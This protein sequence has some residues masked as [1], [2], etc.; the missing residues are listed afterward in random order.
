MWA[1]GSKQ[2][3]KVPA[4]L[5]NKATRRR[6]SAG[7]AARL[8]NVRRV[9]RVQPRNAWDPGGA[10]PWRVFLAAV[11]A[12]ASLDSRDGTLRNRVRSRPGGPAADQRPRKQN[13]ARKKFPQPPPTCT[14]RHSKM[15]AACPSPWHTRCS[16]SVSSS[17]RPRLL[18]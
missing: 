10:R 15:R 14:W 17:C 4:T 6:P 12:L 1:V 7:D 2:A 11:G 13:I 5:R 9:R 16:N 8:L 3:V 18:S